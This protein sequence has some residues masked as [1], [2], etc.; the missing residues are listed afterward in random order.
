MRK[1][2]YWIIPFVERSR[3]GSTDLWF[4][5]V[6]ATTAVAPRK[7]DS[8]GKRQ[9]GT[10][11]GDGVCSARPRTGAWLRGYMRWSELSKGTRKVCVF[12]YM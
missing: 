11:L 1:T 8:M 3:T 7:R 9:E 4:G 5:Y 12:H 10:L 6:S 2:A